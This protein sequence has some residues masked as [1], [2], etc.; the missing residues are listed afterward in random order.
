MSMTIA[1]DF[2]GHV[3]TVDEVVSGLGCNCRCL[4][5]GETL[6]ARK[7]RQ[8]THH[9]SHASSKRACRISLE[10]FVHKYAKQL[11]KESLGLQLPLMPGHHS[12]AADSSAWWDFVSV[13]EEVWMGDFRPDLV[14]ELHDG[15]LAVEFAYT[16]FVDDEKQSKIT[17]RG[18]RAI[19]VNLSGLVVAPTIDGL[20]ELRRVILHDPSLKV[21]LHPREELVAEDEG[22]DEVIESDVNCTAVLPLA[23]RYT[24]QGLWVDV[25]VLPF[26]EI[27]V[28]S[29]SYSPVVVD[30]LRQLARRYG[31]SYIKKY[32][33]WRFASWTHALLL[34]ELEALAGG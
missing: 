7:G 24:I 20:I 14:A 3:V 9:F 29:V 27:V 28:R 5:C 8:R 4:E 26:G 18:L 23:V 15:P 11:V 19:E 30:L 10:S 13:E 22:N 34:N 12:E 2:Q 6:I 16:S 32:R 17:K 33:N 21:W 25:R 31:G 1:E